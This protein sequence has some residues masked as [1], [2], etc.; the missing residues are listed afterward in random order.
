MS[1]PNDL[2]LWLDSKPGQKVVFIT[3][4]NQK[5]F[6]KTLSSIH[7]FCQFPIAGSIWER[8][9][10]VRF[11]K[12]EALFFPISINGNLASWEAG[13]RA[14]CHSSNREM[15]F[16]LDDFIFLESGEQI[17]ISAAQLES[18]VVRPG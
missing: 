11:A 10:T 3:A 16:I 5:D 6:N 15:A 8:A 2:K 18:K 12:H 4:K 9:V 13:I 1:D 14:M 7:K 17:P